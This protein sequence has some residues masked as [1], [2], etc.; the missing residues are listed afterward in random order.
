MGL[1][2]SV[3]GG[4][5][6][7]RE[8]LSPDF[9]QSFL[10]AARSFYFGCAGNRAMRSPRNDPTHSSLPTSTATVPAPNAVLF[11]WRIISWTFNVFGLIFTMFVVCVP[12]AAP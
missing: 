3:K 10:R 7:P 9:P 5:F 1:H 11:G 4:Q 6:H 8:K 2:R 12:G